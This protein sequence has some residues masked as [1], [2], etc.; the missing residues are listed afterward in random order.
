MPYH[1][2]PLRLV[3]LLVAGL[4]L[5]LA[6]VP[7]AAGQAY[8]AAPAG[9]RGPVAEASQVP[10][11]DPGRERPGRGLTGLLAVIATVCVLG[12]TA[13]AIRTIYARRSMGNMNS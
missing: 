4:L 6:G 8:A 5:V 2:V 10:A 13:G 1:Q 9:G 11:R 7:A 12:V 3:S